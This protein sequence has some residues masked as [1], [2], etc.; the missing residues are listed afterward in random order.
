MWLRS[1]LSCWPQV[2]VVPPLFHIVAQ[3][4]VSDL[5]YSDPQRPDGTVNALSN[6]LSSCTSCLVRKPQ[7]WGNYS[8][9]AKGI[10]SYCGSCHCEAGFRKL[11]TVGSSALFPAR[12]G[13]DVSRHPEAGSTPG[14]G[15]YG[16]AIAKPFSLRL[17]A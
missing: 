17:S 16:V 3:L 13:L 2:L 4:M 14:A 15:V 5:P 12:L 10:R 11:S 7:R 1:Y 6:G 9:R 8:F